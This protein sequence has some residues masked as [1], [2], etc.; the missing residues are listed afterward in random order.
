[1]ASWR[2]ECSGYESPKSSYSRVRHEILT[3][4]KAGVLTTRIDESDLRVM[5]FGVT[6]SEEAITPGE[7]F[8]LGLDAGG[9]S[10]KMV[11]TDQHGQ[12][13][14][15]KRLKPLPGHILDPNARLIV[16]EHLRAALAQIRPFVPRA[17]YGGFTGLT[18]TEGLAEIR[19][20]IAQELNLPAQYVRTS[21]DIE[22]AYRAHF[23]P[24][25]GILVY[26]GTGSIAFH[27]RSDGSSERAGGHGY[28]I[29][30]AGAGFSIGQAALRI[31]MRELDEGQSSRRG[32]RAPSNVLARF[33]FEHAKANTWPEL[34]AFVYATG[35][36]SVAG[37]APLVGR[38]ASQGDATAKGILESAG[39][40][41]LRLA[42][43]MRSRLGELPLALAG[44]A[45]EIS[46]ILTQIISTEIPDVH[47]THGGFAQAA[48]HLAH[49]LLMPE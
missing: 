44:G 32:E 2:E 19:T 49:S 31:V 41:L 43:I 45:L 5:L 12:V 8:V 6:M 3:P 42:R 16:L 1:M 15:E 20:L 40:E 47:I 23:N 9:S 7:V 36:S 10:L 33:V 37:F 14:L 25:E 4:L 28:L 34:S 35:R 17:V 22:L 38:A 18:T 48:A 24:G 21:S 30:D 39:H 11:V 27:L 26:A 46:P 29:D 13:H